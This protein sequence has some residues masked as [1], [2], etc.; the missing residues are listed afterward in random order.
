[1]ANWVVSVET[2]GGLNPAVNN[3][4]IAGANAPVGEVDLE[5]RERVAGINLNGVVYGRRYQIPK[6]LEA[7]ASEGAIVS[8]ASIHAAVAILGNAAYAAPKYGDIGLTKNA[9]A[10]YSA[11]GLRVNA[12]GPGYVETPPLKVTPQ[13][14]LNGLES[15]HPLGLGQPEEVANLTTFPLSDK[16][17][18]MTGAYALVDGGYTRV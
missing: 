14:I 9:A 10:E 1:M 15:K 16:A 8:M 11:W 3:A 18:Y 5:E 2:Y 6:I 17:S 7:G 12:V 13:Y 4:G